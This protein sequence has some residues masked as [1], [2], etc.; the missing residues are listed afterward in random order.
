MDKFNFAVNLVREAQLIIKDKKDKFTYHK[1][2]NNSDLV[3]D[4]DILVEDF[5]SRKI[6]E[7]YNK[8]SILGE[9]RNKSFNE[10]SFN[11][12]ILDPIDG[13]LNFIHQGENFA[14]SLA[15][16]EKKKPIFGIVLD[17]ISDDLY[18]AIKGEGAFYNDN[19]LEIQT[20][21]PLVDSIVITSHRWIMDGCLEKF[22]DKIKSVRHLRYY[23]VASLEICYIARGLADLYISAK[24]FPWDYAAAMIIAKEVGL[25]AKNFKNK[26]LDGFIE[27]EVVI[28]SEEIYE[29]VFN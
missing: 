10:D 9:E 4:V 28:T 14:I 8:D 20:S 15:Y 21:K 18:Y 1:K 24:L 29:E 19:K 16:Y 22:L 7:R 13:T 25:V 12:W 6:K 17:V 11:Q 26:N 2:T 27:S 3:T 23:G 5:I